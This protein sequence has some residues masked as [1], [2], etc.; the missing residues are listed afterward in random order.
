MLNLRISRF[1][2]ILAVAI[3]SHF[4]SFATHIVGLDLKYQHVSDSTY[5]IKLIAFADCGPL[6]ATTFAT[7]PS[8]TPN[9]CVFVGSTLITTLVL[10][11]DSPST[12][13]LVGN[14]CTTDTGGT[15]CSSA[16]SRIPGIKKFVYEIDY[17]LPSSTSDYIFRFNGGMG[18]AAATG[19]AAALTNISGS[20]TTS[21]SIALDASLGNNSSPD[22]IDI[23]N[24]FYP[25][26]FLNF[27]TPSAID[28]DGDSLVYSLV[29]AQS[30]GAGCGATSTVTYVGGCSGAYPLLASS[31]SFDA[32]SGQ[33]VF[34]PNLTQRALI[35]YKIS[36]YRHGSLIG[37]TFREMS[38]L[39]YDT[40]LFNPSTPIGVLANSTT[41]TIT[42]PTH[43]SMFDTMGAFAVMIFPF[44]TDTTQNIKVTP[45][46]LP[47]GATFVTIN[48]ST[49]HPRC[50][51]TWNTSYM[52]SGAN[53]FY[54]NYKDDHC[55]I[56]G[57]VTIGYVIRNLGHRPFYSA[58]VTETNRAE[59]DFSIVPNPASCNF[60]VQFNNEAQDGILSIID[61]SG[62][63]LMSRNVS[64][65]MQSIQFN[66]LNLA[67]GTYFVR[68]TN[69]ASSVVKLLQLN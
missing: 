67:P 28:P 49:P 47:T 19:R 1:F 43:I 51:F 20:S 40:S 66:D 35:D 5:K 39:V 57:N 23:T 52:H 36:E 64:G 41:G 8:A 46:S 3:A 6:S 7:L 2:A 10:H 56:Q 21:C 30:A 62:K 61:C 9:V 4:S 16:S 42:D 29:D 17:T 34:V 31:Y 54:I 65:N 27:Y 12:G 58:S 24:Y 59:N 26:N 68:L 37:T 53:I 60:T 25:L 63:L 69:N 15:Q 13:V 50:T 18:I 33:M 32:G 45:V 38:A 11:I 44:E 14:V 22:M 55:P 48:D